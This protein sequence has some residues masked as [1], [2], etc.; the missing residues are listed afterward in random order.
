MN[1]RVWLAS[2]LTVASGYTLALEPKQIDVAV[3]AVV[4]APAF[5]Y[6][7]IGEWGG[8]SVKLQYNKDSQHFPPVQHAA[9]IKSPNGAVTVKYAGKTPEFLNSN[10]KPVGLRYI[11]SI[12]GKKLPDN[13]SAVQILPAAEAA[14]GKEVNLYFRPMTMIDWVARPGTY[15]AQVELVFE[16]EA[17]L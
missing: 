14:I 12:N 2:A 8:S 3:N 13:G 10:G 5:E 7:P 4:A 11:M 15:T 1:I 6:K 17:P 16:T 9:F